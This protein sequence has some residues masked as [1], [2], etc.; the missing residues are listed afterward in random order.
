MQPLLDRV[1]FNWENSASVRKLRTFVLLVRFCIVFTVK[2]S[3]FNFLSTKNQCIVFSAG[4]WLV[5]E[6]DRA[7]NGEVSL[8]EKTGMII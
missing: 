2:K 7:S 1:P 5:S 3:D 8:N 6:S 4:L